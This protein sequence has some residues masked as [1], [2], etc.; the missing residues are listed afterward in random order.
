VQL[1]ALIFLAVANRY[2]DSAGAI[3]EY[4]G[5]TKGTASQT[6]LA[7]ERR[8]LI[9]KA[10]DPVDGRVQHC[11]LTPEGAAIVAS[12]HPVAILADAP[13]R[14]VVEA[15][16]AAVELLRLMQRGRD[17]RTFGQCRTCSQFETHGTR[18]RC[19]LT[20]ERLSRDDS[21]R[22]CR[23]HRS[24]EARAQLPLVT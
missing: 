9:T 12:A 19:G 1:E 24:A 18:Y 6:L 15:E 3:A 8:G 10:R 5:V 14:D 11:H 16:K 23:E 20:G 4:L 21:L 17:H 7:L 13:E 22:I 2:S